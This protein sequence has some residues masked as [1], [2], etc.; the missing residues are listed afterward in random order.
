MICETGWFKELKK[1]GF[2][3][4]IFH[5]MIIYVLFYYFGSYNVSPVILCG[6]IFLVSYTFSYFLSVMMRKIHLS[7]LLGE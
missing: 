5:P 2:G 7:F 1:N 3:I 6:L 4:Y